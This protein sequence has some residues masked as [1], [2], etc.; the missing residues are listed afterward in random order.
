DVAVLAVQ[1][2]RSVMERKAVRFY[3]NLVP[4]LSGQGPACR[5]RQRGRG[6]QKQ[7]LLHVKFPLETDIPRSPWA[8]TDNSRFLRHEEDPPHDKAAVMGTGRPPF[9]DFEYLAA[10]IT[11]R[12][13]AQAVAADTLRR[14]LPVRTGRER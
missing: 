1:H 10:A 7:S 3:A 5:K 11:R 13:R 8:R 2:R 6:G 4:L 12:P 14:P 9:P